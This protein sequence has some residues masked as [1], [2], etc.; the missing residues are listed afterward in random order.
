MKTIS[1][2]KKEKDDFSWVPDYQCALLGA[3][4]L[5][6]AQRLI[7]EGILEH[8]KKKQEEIK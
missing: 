7:K 3:A 6:F 5:Q 4:V 8:P 1:T 2:S